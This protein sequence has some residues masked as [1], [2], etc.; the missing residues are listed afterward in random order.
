MISNIYNINQLQQYKYVVV[1]SKYKDKILLSRHKERTTWETQGGH[2]EK[3]ETPIE[4][5][6]RELYEESGAV[7]YAMTPLCDYWAGEPGSGQ[8]AA[9]MVFMAEIYEL[10]DI[11]E[12]EIQEVNVFEQLPNN[13]TYPAITPVL[14]AKLEQTNQP[15]ATMYELVI[16]LHN[17]I[18]DGSV[19]HRTAVRGIIQKNGKYLLIHSKY[20]DHK[21]PGGGRNNGETLEQTLVREVQEETGYNV[22]IS[23]ITEGPVVH[24]RRK[25][26]TED[27]MIMDSHYFYCEV[28]DTSG[29]RNLDD[30]EAEYDYQVCWMTLDEAIVS[31][32][33][34]QDKEKIPWIE[35]DTLVMKSL[36]GI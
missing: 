9:G 35:R 20:G 21:F 6:R 8:G 3:G 31:N 27:L 14:F 36:I 28:D 24:E 2:I 7:K 17:Y 32:E 29:E 10:G 13:L 26:F 5:A 18:K 33:S 1:I 11:P 16:D 34:I 12:S 23:S 15:L 19:F 30:Y 22:D 25:G 4:A